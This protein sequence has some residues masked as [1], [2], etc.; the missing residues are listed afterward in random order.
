VSCDAPHA[1]GRGT[2]PAI[3]TL[4]STRTYLLL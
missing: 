3:G 4:L 1:A 2:R